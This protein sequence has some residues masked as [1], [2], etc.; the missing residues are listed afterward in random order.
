MG[1]RY[2]VVGNATTGASPGKTLWS[3]MSATTIRPRIYDIIIGSDATPADVA[4]TFRVNRATAEGTNTTWTPI[5]ID[6]GDPASLADAGIN[7]SAEPTYT[8]NAYL[9]DVAMNQRSTQRWV[10]APGSEF[11]IAA[12]ASAGAGLFVIHASATPTVRSTM[13]FEE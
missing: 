7:H 3:L 1:R 9:L 13:L 11:V 10:A 8:A 12:S 5:A 6:N 4:L 2:S